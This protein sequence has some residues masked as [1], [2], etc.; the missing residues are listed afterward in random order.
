MHFASQFNP[1]IPH[2]LE[3]GALSFTAFAAS[4]VAS[5]VLVPALEACFDLGHCAWEAAR[6]RNVLLTHVHQDH[7]GGVVRHLSLRKMTGLTPASRVYLPAA[8]RDAMADVLR[9]QQ[10]LE[11]RESDGL[12]LD[13]ILHG[14]SPGQHFSLGKRWSV[15]AFE[16]Q[17]RIESVGYT[18]S[19]KRKTLLPAWHGRPGA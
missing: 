17:H 19:E 5:Y 1:G 6:L 10:R 9:A 12:E 14:V 11:R 3:F 16:V 15:E 18:V 7:A 2:Q 4:G 8:S 13:A